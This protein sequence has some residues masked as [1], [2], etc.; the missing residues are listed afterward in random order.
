MNASRTHAP[1]SIAALALGLAL[2]FLL[3]ATAWAAEEG[4]QGPGWEGPLGV[5]IVVVLGLLGCAGVGA[6]A[7]LLRIMLPGVAAAADASIGRLSTKRLLLIGVVPLIGAALVAQGVG[8]AGSEVLGGIFL[9]VVGL[10]IAIAILVGAM[11]ALPRIGAG[12]MRSGAEAAPLARAAVGGLV[13]GLA[14]VSWA[15]PPLGFLISLLL[16][17]WLLGTGLGTCMRRSAATPPSE[18]PSADAAE[19]PVG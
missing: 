3:P 19:S 1:R 5:L 7:L 11:A 13:L 9:L 12:A 6:T 2:C 17:G 15:L 14:M 18:A 16:A 8:L 4:G 10:P